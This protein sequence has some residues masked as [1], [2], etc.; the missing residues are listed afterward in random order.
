M[1]KKNKNH[2]LIDQVETHA[3]RYFLSGSKADLG[4]LVSV[5]LA[6]NELITDLGEKNIVLQEEN[7]RL[8]KLTVA[9]SGADL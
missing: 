3:I 1:P 6:I 8:R 2:W 7:E 5:K 9:D 4:M